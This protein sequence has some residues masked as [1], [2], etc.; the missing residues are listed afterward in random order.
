MNRVEYISG[1]A[2]SV[3]PPVIHFDKS[4]QLALV[5]WAQQEGSVAR[6]NPFDTTLVLP[7]STPLPGNPDHVQEYASVADGYR[8]FYSTLMRGADVYGYRA[9]LEAMAVGNCACAVVEAVANSSWGTWYH[10][11]KAATAGMLATERN[12][13]VESTKEV[14]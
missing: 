4:N 13:T 8:A 7:G 9:I 12:F 11:P 6:N 3:S 2:L 14:A 1:L 5:A 10:N